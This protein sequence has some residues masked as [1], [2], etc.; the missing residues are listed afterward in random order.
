M[1]DEYEYSGSVGSESEYDYGSDDGCDDGY[2][3]GDDGEVDLAV[4]LE[5]TYYL[6]DGAIWSHILRSGLKGYSFLMHAL[7]NMLATQINFR[8]SNITQPWNSS[9][10]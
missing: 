4:D 1:S 3:E 10:K 8:N 6:A 2:S 9:R 5:N 7:P